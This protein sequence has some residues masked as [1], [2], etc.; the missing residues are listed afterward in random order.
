MR[1]AGFLA[2]AGIIALETMV[3]RLADDHS[4]AKRLALGLSAIPGISIDPDRVHTNL[5]FFDIEKSDKGALAKQLENLG[6]RGGSSG[7]RWRFVTHYGITSDDIDYA[8]ESV[9]KIFSQ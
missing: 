5:V 6:I 4:N 8:L 1:Q 7:S 2:A 3:E 9:N